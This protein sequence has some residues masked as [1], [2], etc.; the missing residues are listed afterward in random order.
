MCTSFAIGKDDTL[1]SE[2]GSTAGIVL[3]LIE[4]ICGRGY[5][6]YTGNFYTSPALFAE[7]RRHGFEA[8]GTL[9]LNRRGV[10]PEAKAVL[11]RGEIRRVQ[12][13]DNMVVVQWHDKRTVSVLSTVHSHSPVQTE[14]RSRHA[15]DGREVVEKP[16][17]VVEY[18]KFMGGVDRGDQLLSYYGFPH[19]MVKWWR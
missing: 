5:H 16:E 18:N 12:V 6:L 7:L 11:K 4:P 8:C 14:R 2:L 15:A 9:R 19:R 13:G 10:P 1:E 3:R 17:A